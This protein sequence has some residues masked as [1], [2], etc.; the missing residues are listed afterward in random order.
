MIGPELIQSQFNHSQ[1]QSFVV[2]PRDPKSESFLANTHQILQKYKKNE[3][4]KIR[5]PLA[6]KKKNPKPQVEENQ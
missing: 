3:T 5:N 1:T 2:K 6:T 4:R